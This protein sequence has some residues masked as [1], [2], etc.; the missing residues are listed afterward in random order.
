MSITACLRINYIAH[1]FHWNGSMVS[2]TLVDH[3]FQFLKAG[4]IM[5]VIVFFQQLSTGLITQKYN[6]NNQTG[7][8]YVLL[9]ESV[10]TVLEKKIPNN[11]C[12]A[13]Y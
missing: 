12:L 3:T 13:F 11:C 1:H 10:E 5:K 7:H 8:K 9:V 2:S 4:K 6:D